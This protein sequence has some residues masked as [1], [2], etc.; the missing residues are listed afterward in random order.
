MKPVIDHIQLTVQ[1]LNRAEKFYDQLMPLLG[2]DLKLKSR[3]WVEAHELD[4]IEYVHEVLTIAINSPRKPFRD[5]AVHRRKPGSLHHL[6]FKARSTQEVDA[7]F[8]EIKKT[9]ARIIYEPQYFP[10]HGKEYYAL[11][12]KDTEGLKYEIVFDGERANT[13]NS[14]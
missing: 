4:V 11:F 12:F 1:D 14:V 6:A 13:G 3:G 5:E 9:D 10:Q 7:L 8:E 2:Y